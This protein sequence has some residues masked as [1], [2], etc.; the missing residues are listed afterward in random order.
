MFVYVGIEH[1]RF[2]CVLPATVHP[3]T[4]GPL[5]ASWLSFILSGLYS[6]AAPKLMK[7]S[8]SALC[9]EHQQR[10][11][12]SVCSYLLTVQK[13][14]IGRISYP[15]VLIAEMKCID[16]FSCLLSVLQDDW[17]E[18]YKLAGAM[19]FRFPQ[20]VGQGVPVLLR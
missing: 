16:I 4:S 8:R 18:G 2:F 3:L 20:M 6:L 13:Q 17:P 11:I 14:K 1:L 7:Y 19:N 12:T 5:D 10:Y 15:L 9:L